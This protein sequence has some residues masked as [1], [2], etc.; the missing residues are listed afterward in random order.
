MTNHKGDD[1]TNPFAEQFPLTSTLYEPCGS[2][3]QQ[4]LTSDPTTNQ[5]WV[6]EQKVAALVAVIERIEASTVDRNSAIEA[7]IA[8]AKRYSSQGQG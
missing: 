1:S 5:L 7:A 8:L 3:C 6:E 2:G 4:I